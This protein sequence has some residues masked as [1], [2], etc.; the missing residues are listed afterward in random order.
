MKYLFKRLCGLF[1]ISILIVSCSQTALENSL[2]ISGNNREQLE[3]VLRHYSSPRDSLKF[4]AVCFL[5]ENMPGHYSFDGEM[6]DKYH[7]Y[8]DSAFSKYS[9]YYRSYIKTVPLRN[10]AVTMKLKRKY[11]IKNISSDFLIS[12]IDNI[13]RERERTPWLDEM[14]FDHFCEYVLPYRI[15]NEPVQLLNISNMDKEFLM[16]DSILH[17]YDNLKCNVSMAMRYITDKQESYMGANP[18]PDIVYDGQEIDYSLMC[19]ESCFYSW[20]KCKLHNIPVA[21][22]FI[23]FYA[24]RNNGHAWLCAIDNKYHNNK[25]S[26]FQPER[27]ARIYRYTFSRQ[28]APEPRRGEF[29]PWLFLSPFQK[30]VTSHYLPVSNVSIPFIEYDNTGNH[31]AYLTIFNNKKWEAIAFSKI[32][33]KKAIF[34]EMGRGIVYLPVIYNKEKIAAF[35]YPFALDLNGKVKILK[36]DTL[37]RQDITITRK[38]PTSS[39]LVSSDLNLLGGRIEASNHRD[40]RYCDTLAIIESL[41]FL[42]YKEV[43]INTSKSYRYWRLRLPNHNTVYISELEWF[44]HDKRFEGAKIQALEK[45]EIS[46]ISDS[47]PL[48]YNGINN[49]IGIDCEKPISLSKIRYL[50]RNDANNIFEKNKYELFYYTLKGWKSLGQ[51]IAYTDQLIFNDVPLNALFWLRNLDT[52]KEERIF[53]IGTNGQVKFW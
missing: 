24:N 6:L 7:E 22:D 23:P 15:H 21:Y 36:P 48:S 16:D 12:Y 10:T 35:N 49:W 3:K 41:S 42:R 19:F 14:D 2:K 5:I 8:V 38:Y 28:P 18:C 40:F 25:L 32:E 30:N 29:I 11:D 26:T 4:R 9:I 47:D 37:K 33:D 44:E 27:A 1:A 31:Y 34:T 17:Y 45:Q 20:Y 52:G 39:H 43:A 51:K 53:T 50:L 13:F 46:S